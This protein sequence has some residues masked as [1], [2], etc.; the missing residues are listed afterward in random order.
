[1]VEPSIPFNASWRVWV[2]PDQ[3]TGKKREESGFRLIDL[4]DLIR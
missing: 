4:I 2:Y 1:M 3:I